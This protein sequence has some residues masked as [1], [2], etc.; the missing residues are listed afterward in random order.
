MNEVKAYQ[1][2]HLFFI[3]ILAEP[4]IAWY[5]I[6]VAENGARK[7]IDTVIHKWYIN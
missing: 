1:S 4:F 5:I 3:K 7:Y 6:F 2:F